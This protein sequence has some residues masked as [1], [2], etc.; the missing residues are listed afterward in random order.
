MKISSK[1]RFSLRIMLH[2]AG[3]SRCNRLSQGRDIAAKQGINEPYLEQIMIVL[4]KRGLITTVRGRNGGYQLARPADQ[5]TIGDLIESFESAP[6]SGID[7]NLSPEADASERIW[8]EL[9]GNFLKAAEALTL[10]EIL[11][12]QLKEF[13]DFVI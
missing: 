6:A 4:K 9:L 3:Q 11:D 10:A 2:V 13:P 7:A 5:V 12:S 1:A 8:A